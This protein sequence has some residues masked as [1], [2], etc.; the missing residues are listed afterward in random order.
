MSDSDGAGGPGF[1]PDDVRLLHASL[2]EA[3]RRNAMLTDVIEA[4]SLSSDATIL[5]QRAVELVARACDATGGFVYL[6][7]P[8][9]D[10]LVLR[11]AT[12]GRQQAFVN[13]LTLRLGEGITGWAALMRRSALIHDKLLDDP[14]FFH[15]PSAM[16]ADFRS[17]L[18]VPILIPG[19]D[20]VGVFSIYSTRSHAFD[21][22][23]AESI[24]EVAK[25]LANGIDR[26]A[27]F[28]VRTRQSNALRTLVR[29]AESPPRTRNAALAAIAE[30]CLAI[31]PSSLCVVELAD[32]H[33]DGDDTVGVSIARSDQHRLPQRV[34]DKGTADS[35]TVRAL[36]RGWEPRMES[37]S[38]P[39]RVGGRLMG[40]IS[41]HRPSRFAGDDRL[42][43]EAVAN[44]AAL[45]LTGTVTTTGP[46]PLD[47]LIRSRDAAV[48]EKLLIEFGWAA[49]SLVT[50]FVVLVDPFQKLAQHQA[51][52]IST[53]IVEGAAKSRTRRLIPDAPGC[54]AGLVLGAIVDAEAQ[55][56]LRTEFEHAL[57][58]SG[59]QTHLVIG[60]GG[61]SAAPAGVVEGLRAAREAAAWAA[62][63]RSP[64]DV[65]SHKYTPLLRSATAI[66]AD[67][68]AELIRAQSDIARIEQYDRET[69]SALLETL[70]AHVET[71]GSTTDAAARLYIHRNTLRQ[72]LDRLEKL[73]SNPLDSASAW[74]I[75]RLAL[76]IRERE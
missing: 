68:R 29:L 41:C 64:P 43:L 21:E 11:A 5:A 71:Q 60:W 19:G 54:V 7:E 55:E 72:R 10:V 12:E 33:A 46:S 37:I 44:Y 39:I 50:P 69:G 59:Q 35:A 23:M 48:T 8:D 67:L 38:Q 32:P 47:E 42:L 16:E 73:L 56:E 4:L 62:V 70:R 57:A 49:K 27:Q 17:A 6:W 52:A 31:I 63:L 74:F 76:L 20:A 13:R 45:V 1:D 14:R 61:P 58:D 3:E 66:A 2:R 65:L 9:R 25:L 75:T 36:L 24:G 22:G 18:V 26:A 30:R 28:E 15:I 51:M 40:T 34:L 53:R